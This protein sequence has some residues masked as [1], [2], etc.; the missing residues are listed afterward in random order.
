[1]SF[2]TSSHESKSDH[3]LLFCFASNSIE[4]KR[5]VAQFENVFDTQ[6]FVRNN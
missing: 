4:L 6:M 2:D 1:M 3:V 5:K